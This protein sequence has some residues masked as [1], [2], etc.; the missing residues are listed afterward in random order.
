[1][2]ARRQ[3]L[4]R[5]VAGL[6]DDEV[7]QM[8]NETELSDDEVLRVRRRAATVELVEQTQIETADYVFGEPM[9]LINEM[10]FDLLALVEQK[11]NPRE[12]VP[13]PPE[14]VV[15]PEIEPPF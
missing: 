3:E 4:Q 6:S 15:G 9:G 7:R 2:T 8:L 11:L 1:M 12:P 14:V 5:H 13:E 10:A